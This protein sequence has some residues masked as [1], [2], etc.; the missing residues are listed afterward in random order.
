MNALREYSGFNKIALLFEAIPTI[1][2]FM[3]VL[4]DFLEDVHGFEIVYQN[5]FPT[6]T[7]DFSSFL[8]TI[9]SSG[10]EIACPWV[11][12]YDGVVLVRDW[13]EG[14]FPF[15]LWGLNSYIADPDGWEVTEGKCECTTNT[16]FPTVAGYPLTSK[17]LPFREAYI[18]RWKTAPNMMASYAY[19]TLRFILYDALERAGTTETEAVIVALEAAKVETSLARNFVFTKSHDVLGGENIN[20]PDEDLMVVMLFQ[21]QNGQQVPMYPQKI[22]EETGATY[23]FPPWS[24]PWGK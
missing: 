14:Q 20:N 13:Y 5:T 22:K 24:G 19:D 15:V 21:W 16:G 6:G 7:L 12:S 8:S 1:A 4:A 2:D 17:T 18:E 3:P 9:E 10:A 11:V 23:K